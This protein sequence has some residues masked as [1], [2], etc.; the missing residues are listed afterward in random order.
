M[1]KQQYLLYKQASFNKLAYTEDEFNRAV[2]E[3]EKQQRT[4]MKLGDTAIDTTKSKEDQYKDAFEDARNAA[5]PDITRAQTDAQLKADRAASRW[6]YGTAAGAG[7]GYLGGSL[8]ANMIFGDLGDQVDYS[9]PNV[10]KLLMGYE[11]KADGT[12]N[13]DKPLLKYY[14]KRRKG[15]WGRR[16]GNLATRAALTAGGAYLGNLA[17]R[18]WYTGQDVTSGTGS[19]LGRI[20]GGRKK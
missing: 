20:F 6:H 7:I 18:A 12:L 13:K 5:Q 1:N 2:A 10:K 19:W 15:D 16:I 9:D 4:A 17:D 3:Y 11:R 14:I 8:L